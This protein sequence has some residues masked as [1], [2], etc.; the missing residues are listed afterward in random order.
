MKALLKRFAEDRQGATAI[1]YSLIAVLL[2]GALLAAWPSF[3]EGF[4]ASWTNAG[5]VIK[6]AVK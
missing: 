2:A 5:S 4:L 3:Y 1:E 6:N